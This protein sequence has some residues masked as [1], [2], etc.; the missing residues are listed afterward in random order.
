MRVITICLA[1]LTTSCGMRTGQSSR[2]NDL[3]LPYSDKN[4]K[5]RIERLAKD[6]EW[7]VSYKFDRPIQAFAFDN[8]FPARSKHWVLED[9][10]QVGWQSSGDTDL[11]I[12]KSNQP[13]DSFSMKFKTIEHDADNAPIIFF[14]DRSSAIYTRAVTGYEMARSGS[15]WDI[16]QF[17]PDLTFIPG[18]NEHVVVG[19]EISRTKLD[20]TDSRRSMGFYAYF[21][22]IQPQM[23]DGIP[24]IIDPAINNEVKQIAVSAES[25]AIA[26]FRSQLGDLPFKPSILMRQ[27]SGGPQ[28]ASASGAAF[29]GSFLINIYGGKPGAK[30][31][32]IV[33][34]AVIHETA[35]F[36]N[37]LM[38]QS[39]WMDTDKKRLFSDMPESSYDAWIWEG[40][41]EALALEARLK[42]KLISTQRHAEIKNGLLKDCKNVLGTK[43]VID[44]AADG[45]LV[46]VP[47]HCGEFLQ[48]LIVD[49]IGKSRPDFNII[50]LW[51]EIF[52][53]SPDMQI[54]NDVF[55]AAVKKSDPGISN[56]QIEAMKLF[57]VSTADKLDGIVAKISA[58]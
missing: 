5:I 22:N 52:A 49:T 53:A 51:K 44:A 34:N 25:K 2:Q 8:T 48:L 3:S 54:D 7:R 12:G 45:S 19:G 36:W 24:Y 6:N 37:A 9:S 18:E 21:G 28:E 39:R 29:W 27:R 46:W 33:S 10:T 11:V 35:H 32:E 50:S 47:Y 14:S 13:F 1:L 58:P 23:I 17:S 55:F 20:F 38:Y 15:S 26:Y 31:A 16:F 57:L 43:R 30:S 4:L 40:G 41:A 56:D 42:I